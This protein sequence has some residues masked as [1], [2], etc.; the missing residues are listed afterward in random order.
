MLHGCVESTSFRANF[1]RAYLQANHVLCG[2]LL[3]EGFID[4]MDSFEFNKIAGALLFSVLIFLGL[5]ALGETVF[6]V[7]A[8]EKPGYAV[9]VAATTP[10]GSGGGTAAPAATP[11]HELLASADAT[12]GQKAF[13]KCAACHKVDA[14]ASGGVGPNL[15][16]IVGKAMGAQDGFAYSKG[17]VAVA[18]EKGPWSYENLNAFLLKP[19]AFIPG[20]KMS[21]AG[22]KK[23][24]DRANLMAYLKSI[25]PDA[26][27][28]PTE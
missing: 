16:G 8:P 13:K 11:L 2:V 28:Y 4:M 14:G 3:L 6:H 23:E 12:K 9:E 1:G 27:A 10:G 24:A 22:V 26:P 7:A 20:T 19:K 21:F 17:L 25:S 15:A 18:S 5:R